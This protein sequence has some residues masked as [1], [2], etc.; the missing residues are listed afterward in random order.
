MLGVERN[1]QSPL[2][3]HRVRVYEVSWVKLEAW[4]G[5]HETA[6]RG[7]FVVIAAGSTGGAQGCC[8]GG[9]FDYR[10]AGV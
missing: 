10:T 3:F 1:F 9:I 7:L 6:L 8:I 4:L 2:R 5:I